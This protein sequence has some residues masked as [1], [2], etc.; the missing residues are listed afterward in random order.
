MNRRWYN[1]TETFVNQLP[2][3][4][5]EMIIFILSIAVGIIDPEI[6]GNY[7]FTIGPDG[8]DQID[9]LNNPMVFPAPVTGK[10]FDLM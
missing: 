10:K 6:F 1:L 2:G 4:I 8:R 7:R 3:H 9:T 5:P